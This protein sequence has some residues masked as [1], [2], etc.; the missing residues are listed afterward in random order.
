MQSQ[1]GW[2]DRLR[3]PVVSPS[4]ME[5]RGRGSGVE[6]TGKC[7]TENAVVENA[8]LKNAAL[9]MWDLKNAGPKKCGTWNTE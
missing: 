2:L 5:A 6:A 8:G 4:E 1:R 3:G 9:K 7:R